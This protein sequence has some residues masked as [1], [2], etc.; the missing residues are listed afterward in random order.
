MREVCALLKD[1]LM[2]QCTFGLMLVGICSALWLYDLQLVVINL[3]KAWQIL[4]IA[5]VCN[6]RMEIAKLG[7]QLGSLLARTADIPS[8]LAFCT[9][10][11]YAG[12]RTEGVDD[13]R[14][15]LTRCRWGVL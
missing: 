6:E 13:E 15:C 4:R 10:N 8:V 11:I 9:V 2:A 14:V 12:A 7:V 1:C 5:L 3:T